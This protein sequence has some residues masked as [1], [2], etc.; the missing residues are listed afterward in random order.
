MKD[1]LMSTNVERRKHGK[2]N[3]QAHILWMAPKWNSE[4]LKLLAL[5]MVQNDTNTNQQKKDTTAL[6]SCYVWK[7][8]ILWVN[9]GNH[10]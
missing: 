2:F 9:H 5:A 8:S 10:P 7:S 1:E 4:S 6:E 3:E